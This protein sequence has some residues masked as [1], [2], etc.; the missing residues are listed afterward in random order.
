MTTGELSEKVAHLEATLAGQDA[1]EAELRLA[2][3][4]HRHARLATA[5]ALRDARRDL[6]A[7]RASEST[8][9]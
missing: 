2:L 4:Q 9:P 7:A 8:E 5:K 1:R 6:V 3:T